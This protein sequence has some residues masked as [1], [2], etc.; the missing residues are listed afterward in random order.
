MILLYLAKNNINYLIF[1]NNKEFF[2]NSKISH[3]IVL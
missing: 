3:L 1:N 2:Y